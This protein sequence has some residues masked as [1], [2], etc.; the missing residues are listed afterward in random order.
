METAD[1][2]EIITCLNAK[3]GQQLRIP[4]GE[5]LQVTCPACGTNFT[6]RPPKTGGQGK[7]L[8]SENQ[9]K[10]W[11]MGELMLA[12]A[13]ESMTLLKRND[14]AIAS[15][16]SRKQEWEA[17]IE[18]LKVLF[19]LADRVG[20]FYIP[21]SEYLQ[22]LDAVEDAVIDQM[23]NAFRQQAGPG[24]DETPVK[25]SISS[26]LDLGQKLY[27]PYQFM[28][29]EEGKERDRFFQKF[30][31]A[32]GTA[33]GVRGNNTIATSATMCVSSSITAMKLLME[34]ADGGSPSAVGHS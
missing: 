9:R 5:M 13:R 24:Y 1:S 31:E 11:V 19:N 21:V 34:S 12:I 30:G 7:G 29:L 25:V 17:F 26:A 16:V 33:L 4:A 3:C 6:Y 22:F 27:Q 10:A 20:A 8:S 15:K 14:P 28:V 23:N 18:F 32:V 2:P